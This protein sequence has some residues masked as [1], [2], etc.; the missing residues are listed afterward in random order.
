M[1]ESGYEDMHSSGH[2]FALLLAASGGNSEIGMEL[3][4]HCS[5]DVMLGRDAHVEQAAVVEA[6]RAGCHHSGNWNGRHAP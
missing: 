6:V 1:S 5:L 3:T 2:T 4:R